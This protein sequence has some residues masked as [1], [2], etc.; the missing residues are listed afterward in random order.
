[1]TDKYLTELPDASFFTKCAFVCVDLQEKEG[2]A[3]V[4]PMHITEYEMPS[5]WKQAGFTAED[6]NAANDFA[7]YVC[8]PNAAR[9]AEACRTLEIPMIYI[10]WGAR[11][12]DMMDMDPEVRDLLIGEDPAEI[13]RF[14][15]LRSGRSPRSVERPASF[16]G[17]REQ[18]Y[19]L[20][21]TAQDGFKSTPLE[22]M[23]RN[24]CVENL[25]LIGGHTGACLGKTAKSAKLL[26]FRTLC[27]E[28]ATNNAFE[29]N[30]IE[31]LLKC[32]FDYIIQTNC[33]VRRV[34]DISL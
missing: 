21:K 14:K 34:N 4:Q 28:D 6:V 5:L 9:V 26:G 27:V 18:D 25:V 20:A 15:N 31:E 7:F 30:R 29:S 10:H 32:D 1:M 33:F 3:S 13:E 17:V 8:N 16:L 22:F 19:V 12:E 24:L 23:L 2:E 11:Y